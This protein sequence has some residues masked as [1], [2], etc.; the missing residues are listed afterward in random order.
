MMPKKRA[1]MSIIVGKPWPDELEIAEVAGPT[2]SG[3]TRDDIVH[4]L[5][6][7]AGILILIFAGYALIRGDPTL[8]ERIF[9]LAEKILLVALGWFGRTRLK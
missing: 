9:N 6:L 1:K 8:Q 3:D 2:T 7:G 5:V 4:S